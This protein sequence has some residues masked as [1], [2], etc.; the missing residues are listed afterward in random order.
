MTRDGDITRGPALV[1]GTVTVDKA[2]TI[3]LHYQD[4]AVESQPLTW[5]SKPIDAA[6]FLFEI[7]RAHWQ[8]GH[9]HERLIIRD[10]GGGELRSELLRQ[11]RP[12]PR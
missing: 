11:G 5:V 6:F 2:E 3:E 12:R 8:R 7:D 4:G 9:Q 1:W 10:G